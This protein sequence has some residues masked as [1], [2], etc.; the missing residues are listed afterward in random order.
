MPWRW[1]A[2]SF[3]F[4]IRNL[5]KS[6]GFLL[7]NNVYIKL[8]SNFSIFLILWTHMMPSK[9]AD[10]GSIIIEHVSHMNF[11]WCLTHC[12][13][14][15]SQWQSKWSME[16]KDF[17]FDSLLGLRI[18]SSSVHVLM[19]WWNIIYLKTSS[20]FFPQTLVK[21]VCYLSIVMLFLSSGTIKQFLRLISWHVQAE[22]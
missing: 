1:S 10:P 14:S 12:R 17:S 16:S 3:L 13:I 7:C 22:N 19:T 15:F 4:E 11:W 5:S 18:F 6:G 21:M 8:G 9:T 2:S 20:S